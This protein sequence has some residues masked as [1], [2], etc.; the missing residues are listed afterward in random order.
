MEYVLALRNLSD[1][2]VSAVNACE[3]S[4][5]RR[6]AEIAEVAQRKRP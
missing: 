5:Y 3:Q 2:C 6:D 4:L 1:L